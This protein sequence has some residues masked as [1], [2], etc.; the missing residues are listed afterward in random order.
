[1]LDYVTIPTATR[2]LG[3]V[4]SFWIHSAQNHPSRQFPFLFP[5]PFPT[6]S[7][8]LR[9]PGNC[10]HGTSA[11]LLGFYTTR[12]W[13][14]LNGFLTAHS[15]GQV[16]VCDSG[17]HLQVRNWGGQCPTTEWSLPL[18]WGR[19]ELG[20]VAMGWEKDG[21]SLP[22]IFQLSFL[23]LCVLPASKWAVSRGQNLLVLDPP[24]LRWFWVTI[25]VLGTK[26]A[27][28]LQ[29]QQVLL[30]MAPSLLPNNGIFQSKII[31]TRQSTRQGSNSQK[32]QFHESCFLLQ[33]F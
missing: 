31:S 6:A 28:F 27:T 20:R 24:E 8:G 15:T 22:L 12:W 29:E 3:T 7:Y 17:Q 19:V 1:M 30:T 13:L 2:S 11:L 26:P 23:N 25:W 21:P 10:A 4:T 33:C 5:H 32:W 9:G 16:Q 18:E 14:S